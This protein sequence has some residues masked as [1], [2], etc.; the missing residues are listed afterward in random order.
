MLTEFSGRG[1]HTAFATLVDRYGLMVHAVALRVLSNHQDAQDITKAVFLALARE[2]AKLTGQPSV[3]GWLHT[4]SQRLALDALKFSESRQRS[5]QAFRKVEVNMTPDATLST[6]FRREL[7][8]ALDRLPD[9]Y[10][11]PL[12]L[13]HLEEASLD[14]VAK[15]P[16]LHTYTL[17]S[18]LSH[19]RERCCARS[20][21]VGGAKARLSGCSLS[22]LLARPKPTLSPLSFLNCSILQ[23]EVAAVLPRTSWNSLTREPQSSPPASLLP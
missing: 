7:D 8:A 1:S 4:V 3:V 21:V 14:E 16:N 22:Y 12:V 11:Q 2:A 17:R 18:R 20:S 5:E 15:R 13:F 19:T 10:R 23:P 6:V 9:R